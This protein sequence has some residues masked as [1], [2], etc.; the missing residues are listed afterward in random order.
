MN[1]IKL[2]VLAVAM[3]IG[4]AVFTPSYSYASPSSDTVGQGVTAIGGG[5]EK[6]LNLRFQDVINVMLY[7]LGALAVL[8][9][10]LW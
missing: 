8:M 9:I 10:V 7:I 6:A 4:V 3:L 1:K 5:G 2:A